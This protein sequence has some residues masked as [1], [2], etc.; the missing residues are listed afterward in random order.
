MSQSADHCP[1]CNAQLK[2]SMFGGNL[3]FPEQKVK[4][5]N[6]YHKPRADGYCGKCGNVLYEQYHTQRQS[7][8]N[9]LSKE[10]GG[11]IDIMPIVTTHSP[12]GWEYEV[13]GIVTGQS[14]AGTGITAEFSSAINDLFGSRSGTLANKLKGGE[15]YCMNQLRKKALDLGGNAVIASDIDYSELGSIKGMI[16]VC[17]A[18]TAVRIRN[19]DIL[20]KRRVDIIT[21]MTAVND[22]LLQILALEVDELEPAAE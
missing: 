10:L 4:I 3:P 12:V 13:L 15:T 14:V 16:M 22:R 6:L 1:N 18:G 19:I 5:I 9:Q 2:S 7:E 11:I 17:M 8:V 21:R 20:G